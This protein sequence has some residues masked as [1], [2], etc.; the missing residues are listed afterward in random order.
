MPTNA[1]P[2]VALLAENLAKA[3]ALTNSQA[4]NLQANNNIQLRNRHLKAASY[5]ATTQYGHGPSGVFNV[6]GVNRDVYPVIP[7]PLG[8]SSRLPMVRNQYMQEKFELAM[9]VT[10]GS[11]SEPANDCATAPNPGR[12][13]VGFQYFPY[14][15]IIRETETVD[16]NRLG[17]LVDN[18]EPIDLQIV[19]DL[20]DQSPWI[21]DPA[22]S[23]NFL[24]SELGLKYFTLGIE[25]E[26]QVESDVF[27]G[28]PSSNSPSTLGRLYPAGLDLII[29]TGKIDA[30]YGSP[31]T[32]LDSLLVNWN[33]SFYNGTVTLNGQAADIVT[34]MSATMNYLKARARITG[35]RQADWAIA[36]RYD[37]FYALTAI[38]P[39]SY[40]TNGCTTTGVNL[41][42]VNGAEQVE[43]RDEM[44]TEGA[45]FLWING[46]KYPVWITDQITESTAAGKRVSGIY[47]IPLR[48]DG[49]FTTY[50]EYFNYDNEQITEWDGVGPANR[51]WTS[52]NGLYFWTFEQTRYCDVIVAKTQYRLIVRR[53]DLAARIQAVGYNAVIATNVSQPGALYSIP[54]GV[55]I[56]QNPSL[57]AGF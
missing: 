15:K 29:N 44:R 53:T 2:T 49:R 35:V 25:F 3:L 13:T 36:M 47:F 38:W 4:K 18:A 45:E 48:V 43:M 55:G 50:F 26:R 51:R 31:L 33:N 54:S 8:I 14:G 30:V 57:Y 56:G 9:P 37:L 11:G 46:I 24:N 22:R 23:V 21:P 17:Q 12:A 6:P 7:R 39:C 1:D 41:I 32:G 10:A 40:L 42:A 34:T 27:T 19:G 20:V 28:N 52:N 5:S 16:V